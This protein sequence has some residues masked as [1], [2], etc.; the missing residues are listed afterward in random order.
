VPHSCVS[1]FHHEGNSFPKQLGG[2]SW[3][4]LERFVGDDESRPKATEVGWNYL[5][6]YIPN[7]AAVSQAESLGSFE[8]NA[9]VPFIQM[10]YQPYRFTQWMAFH[11]RQSQLAKDITWLATLRRSVFARDASAKRR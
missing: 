2:V 1:L 9:R 5:R 8:E 6:G 7:N 11:V 10:H 4:R 3:L